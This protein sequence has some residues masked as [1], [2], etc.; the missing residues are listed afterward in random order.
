MRTCDEIKNWREKRGVSISALAGMIG[1][2]RSTLSRYESGLIDTIPAD[3]IIALSK[4]LDVDVSQLIKD[5]AKYT[6][7]YESAKNVLR[8]ESTDTRASRFDLKERMLLEGYRKQPKRIQKAIERLCGLDVRQYVKARITLENT[9]LYTDNI[10]RLIESAYA[11]DIFVENPEIDFDDATLTAIHKD[12]DIVEQFA[13]VLIPCVLIPERFDENGNPLDLAACGRIYASSK[14]IFAL[15]NVPA[16]KINDVYSQF[17]KGIELN[18]RLFGGQS[19]LITSE[20]CEEGRLVVRELEKKEY[21]V[22]LICEL[23]L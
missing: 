17:N 15:G 11:Y 9:S 7:I 3:K 6:H 21:M 2:S 16:E 20:G 22:E 13:N 8:Q 5:D 1:V 12:G 18:L 14:D 23:P 10:T 4:V 19:K